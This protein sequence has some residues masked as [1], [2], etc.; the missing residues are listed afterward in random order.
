M[1]HLALELRGMSEVSGLHSGLKAEML[2]KSECV[3]VFES[4]VSELSEMWESA[5]DHK[6]VNCMSDVSG[7]H[8]SLKV[9]ICRGFR[10]WCF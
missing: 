10:Q 9:G 3:M 6:F 7:P 5:A 1:H 2:K 4:G 8:S